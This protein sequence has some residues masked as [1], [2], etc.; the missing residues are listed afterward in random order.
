MLVKINLGIIQRNVMANLQK[1][2][3]KLRNELVLLY[4]NSYD[5]QLGVN[6]VVSLLDW[7]WEI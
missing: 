5:Y 6:L 3:V 4:V 2:G 7:P 1:C